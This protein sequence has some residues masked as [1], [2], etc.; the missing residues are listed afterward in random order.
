MRVTDGHSSYEID[1]RVAVMVRWLAERAE[2]LSG[3][4]K[5]KIEFN[6]AGSRVKPVSTV[7][8]DEETLEI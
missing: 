2:R 4:Q 8:E 7:I 5:V 1:G 6:C 3:H